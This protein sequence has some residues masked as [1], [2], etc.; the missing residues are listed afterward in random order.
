MARSKDRTELIPK[1]LYHELFVESI[2]NAEM[3]IEEAKLI[4]ESKSKTH[5]RMLHNLAIEE[6]AKGYACLLVASGMIPRSHPL[7]RR[8]GKGCVFAGHDVKYGFYTAVAQKLFSKEL[9]KAKSGERSIFA[10]HEAEYLTL[11]ATVQDLLSEAFQKK[12]TADREL[13]RDEGILMQAKAAAFTGSQA[14]K[15][16]FE[17][18]YVD[19]VKQTNG[20]WSVSS[21]LKLDSK[22]AGSQFQLTELVIADVKSFES[23]S[24]APEFDAF[25]QAYR[26]R[27]EQVD[28]TWPKNPIW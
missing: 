9:Q 11:M 26:K 2:R 24:K 28:P 17:W 13:T 22:D 27:A 5:A 7:V 1:E 4:A 10:G 16:R 6:V 8:T 12:G 25:R 15:K 18:M 3:L 20:S 21:P 23:K 19:A 14:T